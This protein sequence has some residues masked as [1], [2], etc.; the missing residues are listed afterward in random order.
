MSLFSWKQLVLWSIEYSCL[1]EDQKTE[2]YAIL[3]R[4]WADFCQ[5]V[6]DK[7]GGLLTGDVIDE[8]TMSKEEYARRA[9]GNCKEE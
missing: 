2:A 9:K 1:E 4:T 7:Y 8:D 6:V 3:K 5:E